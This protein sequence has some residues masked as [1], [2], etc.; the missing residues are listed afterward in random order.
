[1]KAFSKSSNFEMPSEGAQAARIYAVIHKGSQPMTWQG[2]TSLKSCV[3]I[4]FELDEERED[5]MH[6]VSRTWTEFSPEGLVPAVL[7]HGS[8]AGSPE[9]EF[10]EGPKQFDTRDLLDTVGLVTIS[11]QT[12]GDNT[13]ANATGFSPLPRSMKPPERVGG[14]LI[15]DSAS[16]IIATRCSACCTRSFRSRL[17]RR[18]STG[19]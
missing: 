17:R 13:Y 11:H 12:K 8:G 14:S 16:R 15:S 3:L 2:E 7:N 19:L 10:R 18:P 4:K 6:I 1:M 9:E 5:A